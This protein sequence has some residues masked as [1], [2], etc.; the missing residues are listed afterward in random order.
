VHVQDGAVLALGDI[1]DERQQLALLVDHD[2]AVILGRAVE[3][4]DGGVLEGAD[5]SDL[6]GFQA[7]RAGE[8]GQG[9]NGLVARVAHHDVG[10]DV[11]V[12]DNLGFH[13]Q[14][15]NVASR[16][17]AWHAWPDDARGP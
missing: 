10:D 14:L 3:P 13:H 11:R 9:G 1:S 17:R 15:L 4:A 5:G 2:A 7:L 16:S 12:L 8:L 6:R